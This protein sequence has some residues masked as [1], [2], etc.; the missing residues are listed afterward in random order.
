VGREEAAVMYLDLTGDQP[1]K[2]RCNRFRV[3]AMKED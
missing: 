3:T 2:V 1:L